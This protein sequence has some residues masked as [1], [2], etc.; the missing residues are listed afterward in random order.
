MQYTEISGTL[1]KVRKTPKDA[2]SVKKSAAYLEKCAARGKK[3]HSGKNAPNLEKMHLTRK[4][5]HT[6]KNE[7][8][9]E[10]CSP[11]GKKRHPCKNLANSEK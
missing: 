7:E 5:R 11:L 9:V 8:H 4:M 3:P 6:R 2:A 1:A 10:K